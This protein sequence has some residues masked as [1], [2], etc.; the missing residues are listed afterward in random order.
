MSFSTRTG[1]IPVVL[2]AAAYPVVGWLLGDSYLTTLLITGGILALTGVGLDLCIGGAGLMVFSAPAFMLIG[3]MSSAKVA[4]A[5][6]PIGGDYSALIGILAGLLVTCVVAAVVSLVTLRLSG[7]GLGLVTLFLLFAAATVAHNLAWLGGTSGIGGIP[8]IQLGGFV[9]DTPVKSL[10]VVAVCLLVFMTLAYR[11]VNSDV[12]RELA[13]V[14]DDEIAAAASGVRVSL[15]KIEAFIFSCL[16]ASLAGSLLVHELHFVSADVFPVT[17]LL[18][19]LLMLYIGGVGTIWGVAIGAPIVQIGS[20]YLNRVGD[21]GLAIK[22]ICF[23]VILVFAP[24][25]IAGLL[26]W[27]VLRWRPVPARPRH[28][29]P[30]SASSPVRRPRAPQPDRTEVLRVCALVRDFGGLRAVDNV[31]LTVSAR[32]VYALLG[33]NGAGKT[34]LFNL[35]SGAIPVSSG[36]IELRGSDVTRAGSSKMA[37]LGVART[38]QNVRL[39]SGLSVLDNVI[40]GTGAS[41]KTSV[42]ASWGLRPSGRGLAEAHRACALFGLTDLLHE[43]VDSLPIGVQ[44]RVEMAR[45][46]AMGPDL[47]LLD[48]PASGLSSPEREELKAILRRVVDES[49][50]TIVIVEHDVSFVSEV[51]NRGVV[52]EQGRVIFDGSMGGLLDD[53]SVVAAYLGSTLESEHA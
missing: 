43:D 50:T 12:G 24:R 39:F 5:V 52:L 23:V 13:A 7:L 36:R 4:T 44:R 22:G 32:E 2:V 31:D 30:P 51:A 29:D 6:E 16:P 8:S 20:D 40:V 11:Y 27:A 41:K 49:E 46:M 28:A 26:D 15:R 19:V 10:F 17:V 35:V 33:P 3:A 37:G 14:R 53:D 1:M 9:V 45:A 25:G 47:L 21:Y 42:L 38:F 34:T 18:D 48:E